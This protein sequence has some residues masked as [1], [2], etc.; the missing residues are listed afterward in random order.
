MKASLRKNVRNTTPEKPYQINPNDFAAHHEKTLTD[1]N[2]N[3]EEKKE[4]QSR[5]R[6]RSVICRQLKN[7]NGS[8][9]SIAELKKRLR[10]T[11]VD[12]KSK[13]S[14]INIP[15]DPTKL[16]KKATTIVRPKLVPKNFDKQVPPEHPSTAIPVNAPENNK[17]DKIIELYHNSAIKLVTASEDYIGMKKRGG[18][19]KLK[20]QLN[21][22]PKIPEE[23]ETERPEIQKR[24]E[25]EKPLIDTPHILAAGDCQTIHDN[26][27]V[28][29]HTYDGST[30]F[31]NYELPT[32]A[33][34]M[35]QVAKN[36]FQNFTFR[37]IPFVA[38]TSTSPSHNLGV[39]IQQVLS[40]MKG[41][42]P[43]SGISPTLAY[44]IELA[45]NKLGSRPF[46]ALVS[47]LGSRLTNRCICPAARRV[48]MAQLQEQA[49]DVPEEANFDETGSYMPDSCSKT[50][51]A[52]K[53]DATWML[54]P[55]HKK[56]QCNCFPKPGVNF[57]DVCSKY[58]NYVSYS[59]PWQERLYQLG[60]CRRQTWLNKKQ[61]SSLKMCRGGCNFKFKYNLGKVIL[62]N[63]NYYMFSTKIECF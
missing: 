33:S 13:Q 37:T 41:R 10:G 1:V 35:K 54:D 34:K 42:K 12:K 46:S 60:F 28:P 21:I 16:K 8:G 19:N 45:A 62:I 39:N 11:V 40:I 56:D 49:K 17:S 44:N 23:T 61:V 20:K 52:R 30:Y 25:Y 3:T 48:N 32:I 14:P 51:Y 7:K 6:S 4:L 43:L 63:S 9:I 26:R 38:A 22:K 58:M 50:T 55:K 18:Q 27:I 47:N 57:N 59:F 5:K 29:K 36:Y 31:R 15:S 2:N 24:E 53:T